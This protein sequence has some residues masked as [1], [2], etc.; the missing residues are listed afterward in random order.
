M[1]LKTRT[2]SSPSQD[3]LTAAPAAPITP[4]SSLGPMAVRANRRRTVIPNW[5]KLL[6]SNRFALVGSIM[7]LIIVLA[8]IFAPLLTTYDPSGIA[9]AQSSLSPTSGNWFGTNQQGEDIFSQVI[10]GGRLSL[11]IGAIVGV[12]GVSL[13]MIVGM[14]AGYIGGWIDEALG[15]VMNIFLVIPQLPLLIVASAYL[16]VKGGLGMI[17]ILSITGWA[18]G[19]RVLRA[20]TLSLRNRDF[21]QAAYLSGEPTWRIVFFEIMPNM[22]SLMVSSFIFTFIGAILAEAGLEFLGF[23]DINTISWGTILYWAQTNSALLTGE[24]WH[25]LFP[26]LAIAL[27]ITSLVFINYG[28]DAI[29]NPR[30]RAIKVAKQYRNQVRARAAATAAAR[31]TS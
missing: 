16:P 26:G 12:L 8:A 6:L 4:A 25:F 14:L 20:Q 30:L 9:S 10:Y 13:A 17:I 28:I 31:V 29:S 15:V 7:L 18:W 27:T 5:L 2:S 21:V 24:W 3:T 22:I 1:Q 19:G 23:G 11:T